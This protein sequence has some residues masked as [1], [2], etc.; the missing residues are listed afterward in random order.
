[1][2][3]PRRKLRLK[4]KCNSKDIAVGFP[5]DVKMKVHSSLGGSSNDDNLLFD[6]SCKQH[7]SEETNNGEDDRSGTLITKFRKKANSCKDSQ[8]RCKIAFAEE[9]NKDEHCNKGHESNPTDVN[10]Y[11]HK[12]VS[13]R[14]NFPHKTQKDQGASLS[15]RVQVDCLGSLDEAVGGIDVTSPSVSDKISVYHHKI[16]F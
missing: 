3:G 6:N 5:K 9:G 12:L 16:L 4:E 15:R 11:G 8:S 1:M 13:L 7:E 10:V 2:H 14:N